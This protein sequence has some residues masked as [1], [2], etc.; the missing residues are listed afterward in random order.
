MI[1]MRKTWML[2]FTLLLATAC[3]DDEDGGD[4][5]P[6]DGGRD[7]AAD[8]S[9][10][11]DGGNDAGNIDAAVQDANASTDATSADAAAPAIALIGTWHD[12]E[13]GGDLEITSTKFGAQTIIEFD[14]A[15]R[16]AITQN[17][18]DDQYGPSKFSK[19]V[20]TAFMNGGF[21]QCAQDYGKDTAAE[22]KATTMKADPS[23]LA[24]GC[25]GSGFGW[26]HYIPSIEIKGD[27]KS[28]ATDFVVTSDAFGTYQIESYDNAGDKAVIASGGGDAGAASYGKL[29]WTVATPTR[30]YYCIV[31][32]G[33]ATAAEAASSPASADANMPT[34]GC[35]GG[36][37]SPLTK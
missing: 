10:N 5:S 21:Y 32:T 19:Q 36:T 24:M 33:L 7:A 11:L 37:W 8:A 15:E 13:F 17:P 26:T 6:G 12:E 20:W 35:N 30:I 34:E 1:K 14:N 9:S 16:T 31:A 22:A 3:S 4:D 2:A 29:V 18:A 25:G 23:D 28:D 27:W